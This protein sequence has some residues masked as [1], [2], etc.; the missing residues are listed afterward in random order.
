MNTSV[1]MTTRLTLGLGGLL[2]I[3]GGVGL[4]GVA[5]AVERLVPVLV[6]QDAGEA[7]LPLVAM[8]AE[9]RIQTQAAAVQVLKQIQHNTLPIPGHHGEM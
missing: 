2:L 3:A 8:A 7:D 6:V 1:T 5:A 9:L 4:Q